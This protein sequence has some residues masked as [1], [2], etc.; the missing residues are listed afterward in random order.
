VVHE[1]RVARAG[2]SAKREVTD[3]RALPMYLTKSVRS[4]KKGPYEPHEEVRI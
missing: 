1:R 3:G 2:G 4:M